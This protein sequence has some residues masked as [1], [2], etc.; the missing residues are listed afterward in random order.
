MNEIYKAWEELTQGEWGTPIR[1]D[2]IARYTGKPLSEIIEQLASA[3]AN[4]RIEIEL[5]PSRKKNYW[6]GKK[7]AADLTFYAH[8]SN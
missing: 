7:K 3:T 5:I 2:A 1:I 4:Y 6:I 8:P